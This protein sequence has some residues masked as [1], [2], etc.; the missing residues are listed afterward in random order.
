MAAGLIPGLTTI[1]QVISGIYNTVR[2][3]SGSVSTTSYIDATKV[4]RVEPVMVMSRDCLMIPEISN[5]N[6]TIF[7]IF[8]GYYLQALAIGSGITSAKVIN[9][10]DR[11]NP[12]RDLDG[13]LMATEAYE[14]KIPRSRDTFYIANEAYK[15]RLPTTKNIYA[16]E[17][18]K[19]VLNDIKDV[20]DTLTPNASSGDLDSNAFKTAVDP[21]NLAIGKF[22]NVDISTG[23]LAKDRDGNEDKNREKS[24]TIPINIRLAP[25]VLNT[26]SMTHLMAVKRE[27][28]SFIER[29]HDWRSGKISFIKDFMLA[30]DL[31]REHKKALLADEEGVYTDIL[32]RVTK[33]KA[34]GLMT[35]NPSL[36][37]ASAIFVLTES[38]Q[39]DIEY[40]L[41]GKLTN[42]KIREKVFD[43][44]YAM[45]IAI[46]DR[47]WGMVTFYYRGIDRGTQIPLKELK[48]GSKN[49]N[50][51]IMDI[52]KALTQGNAPS[53]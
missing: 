26:Q 32:E 35:A 43:G 3:A 34:Y 44:T 5:V 47:E 25:V 39:R 46:I 42:T 24:I 48:V 13:Y 1:S 52:F 53:F 40:K 51:D 38:V 50:N 27:D 21:S 30:S 4:L 22:I 36:A 2:R 28:T 9:T 19:K 31:I 7:S 29:W 14:N 6:Q 15:Y 11:L 12:N 41:G 37:S 10:L 16:L 17:S 23:K 18:E 49:K 45:I 8:T 20:V 33:N